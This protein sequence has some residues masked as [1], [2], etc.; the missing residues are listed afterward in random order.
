MKNL[1][2]SIFS[3]LLLAFAFAPT[4]S[5][6]QLSV[7]PSASMVTQTNQMDLTLG[8]TGSLVEGTDVGDFGLQATTQFGVQTH[9]T[10]WELFGGPS[11]GLIDGEST[12]LAATGNVGF[13]YHDAAA[14]W[15]TIIGAGVE[16]RNG[17]VFFTGG[18]NHQWEYGLTVPYAGFGVNL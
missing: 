15:N 3:L 7:A 18:V 11:V 17:P 14:E 12:D 16:V 8:A 5:A 4:A 10:R 9:D 13:A 2:A 6:Q 1:T